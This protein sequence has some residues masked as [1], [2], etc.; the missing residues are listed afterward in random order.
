[1]SPTR[2]YRDFRVAALS[3]S[4][5]ARG[6]NTIGCTAVA[7]GRA[8]A[9]AA[10]I[11]LAAGAASGETVRDAASD[12]TAMIETICRQYAAAVAQS[13]LPANLMFSQCMTERH[14]Q[15]SPGSLHYQCEM[16]G[17][18]IIRPGA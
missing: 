10:L 18:M 8:G 7:V 12:Y 6:Q 9:T 15:V 4:L 17:P 5:M 2:R 11:S 3:Q 16:P 13:G 14:C 1:V